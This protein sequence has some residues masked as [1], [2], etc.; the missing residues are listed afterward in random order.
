MGSVEEEMSS[1]LKRS[2][3]WT[4]FYKLVSFSLVWPALLGTSRELDMADEIKLVSDTLAW[5]NTLRDEELPEQIRP[6][7]RDLGTGLCGVM[8]DQNPVYLIED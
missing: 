2:C 4:F 3:R 5:L 8:N 1:I 7:M 6:K